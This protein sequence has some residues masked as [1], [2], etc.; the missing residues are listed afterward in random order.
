MYIIIAQLHSSPRVLQTIPHSYKYRNHKHTDAQ[1]TSIILKDDR[2]LTRFQAGLQ[3]VR[4]L[5]TFCHC[6]L[7][8]LSPNV[9]IDTRNIDNRASRRRIRAGATPRVETDPLIARRYRQIDRISSSIQVL[10]LAC[11]KRESFFIRQLP[12]EAQTRSE[13]ET[14]TGAFRLLPFSRL[15][16]I[17]VGS[18]CVCVLPPSRRRR[19]VVRGGWVDPRPQPR[20]SVTVSV[21][22]TRVV[23][24]FTT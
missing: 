4:N 3:V 6:S 7:R 20:I 13:I 12:M 18:R 2:C 5:R 17:D 14:R 22:S 16:V 23:I 1:N 15:Y 21:S 8:S 9:S 11:Q 19:S 24:P 10:Y